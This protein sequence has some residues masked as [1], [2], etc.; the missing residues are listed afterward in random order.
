MGSHCV[1][2]CQSQLITSCPIA[3]PHSD[4][5]STA[6]WPTS[7]CLCY[8]PP[9]PPPSI[10]VDF[11]HHHLPLDTSLK[12]VPQGMQ[13]ICIGCRG[14]STTVRATA[15][16]TWQIIAV[17]QWWTLFS[18]ILPHLHGFLCFYSLHKSSA[19]IKKKFDTFPFTEVKDIFQDGLGK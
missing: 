16:T 7:C 10:P 8:F 11:S 19:F 17:R 2:E 5:H 18:F 14:R 13:L 1:L 9:L 3:S 4:A 12:V 15:E 6:V